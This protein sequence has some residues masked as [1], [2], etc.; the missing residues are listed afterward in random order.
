[1]KNF[2]CQELTKTLIGVY[3][4]AYNELGN[5]FLEKFIKMQW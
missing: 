3:Y 4:D 2:P 1:M 5:G